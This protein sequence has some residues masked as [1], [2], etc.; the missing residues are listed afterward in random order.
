MKSKVIR[1]NKKRCSKCKKWLL[2]SQFNKDSYRNHGL[3]CTCKKCSNE[4]LRKD[5]EQ[6][7][8]KWI[9]Y[10]R[11]SNLKM[12][13]GLQQNEFLQISKKQKGK[14]LICKK[15]TK[16]LCIDHN[17]KTGK[18]RGLLCQNCNAALGMVDENVVILKDMIR[19]LKNGQRK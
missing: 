5:R 12:R 16:R 14:C 8:E 11:K 4:R 19:Y 1:G 2:F 3:S 18:V 10:N 9:K 6:D 7:R 15:K 13:Y 17:H